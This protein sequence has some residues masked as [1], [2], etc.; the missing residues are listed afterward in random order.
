VPREVKVAWER[1]LEGP[2]LRPLD[3]A[4]LGT[5]DE[6]AACLGR[7]VDELGKWLDVMSLGLGRAV[8][9]EPAT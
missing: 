8:H 2:P 6:V 7:T 9:A 3:F 5:K 1:R 4:S